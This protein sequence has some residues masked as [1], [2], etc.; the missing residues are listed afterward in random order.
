[1]DFQ[2]PFVYY[3]ITNYAG[4]KQKSFKIMKI[5]IFWIYGKS[6]PDTENIRGLNLAAVR[7]M[8]DQMTKHTIVEAGATFD[9]A[10]SVVP[11]GTE[12]STACTVYTK[13]KI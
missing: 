2:I 4:N 5:H 9:R 8:T 7:R 11:S 1:M 13:L 10:K 12:K 6:K 3:Y